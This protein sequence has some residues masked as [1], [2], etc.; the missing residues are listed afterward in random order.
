MPTAL[1]Q[2]SRFHP[3]AWLERRLLCI[4]TLCA[5]LFVSNKLSWEFILA[6]W[7]NLFIWHKHAQG[8]FLGNFEN[9]PFLLMV[10]PLM[11]KNLGSV[12][13]LYCTEMHLPTTLENIMGGRFFVP[14][15]TTVYASVHA[16]QK[17]KFKWNIAQMSWALFK[18]RGESEPDPS[19]QWD[20]FF[21]LSTSHFTVSI[22]HRKKPLTPT[23]YC[24]QNKTKSALL[25]A[26]PVS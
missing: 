14:P 23:I 19:M 12:F 2:T 13:P 7:W 21:F 6:W 26:L 24:G 11:L 10:N 9:S 18:S 15:M 3:Q 8:L 16:A 5:W 4:Y 22:M 17:S 25:N 20:I 1:R